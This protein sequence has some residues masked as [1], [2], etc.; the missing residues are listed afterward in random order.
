VPSFNSSVTLSDNT[1]TLNP[2]SSGNFVSGSKSVNVT[3]TK[4]WNDNQVTAND[5]SSGKSGQSNN[6]NI[7]PGSVQN[8]IVRSNPG[9]LGNEIGNLS[10]NLNNQVT[11]YAAGYDQW[12]NYVRDVVADWGKTGTLDSPSPLSGTSTTFLPTTAQTSGQVYADSSGM[13][14]Y[15]GT[16]TVGSIHYVLIRDADNGGGNVVNTSFITADDTL[17]LYAAAYDEGDNYLGAAIVD[18]SSSGSLQPAISS[19]GMSMITFAPTTAPASGQIVADHQTALDYTTGT[20]TV[21]QGAPV[22]NIVLHPNPKSIPAHPDSFSIITSDVIYD[23]DGN[24]IAEGELFTVSTT[25]GSI[26]APADQ[27]A[28][29]VGHQVSSNWSSQINFTISGESIGGSAIIHANSVGKGNAFGDTTL[30]ISNID[31]VSTNSVHSKVSQGQNNVLVGMTVKNRGT[32]NLIIPPDGASLRFRDSFNI[33]R[34]GDYTVTR[35]DTFS[36]IQS[37]GGQKILNFNVN[38]SPSATSDSISIDGNFNGMVNGKVVNDTTASQVH[39]WLVQTPPGLRIDRITVSADTVTQGKTTTVTMTVQNDGD[40]SFVIDSDSLT[41]WAMTQARD[42]THEYGQFPIPSNPDTIAGHSSQVL[43]YTVQ[44]GAAATLD[45]IVINGKVSGRDVNS[46]FSYTDYNADF[47]DGW[48]VNLASDVLI[49]EFLPDQMTVTSG[50]DRDWYIK[51]AVTNSGGSDLKLDSTRVIFTIGAF[52]ISSQYLVVTPNSFMSGGSDTLGAGQS[53]TLQFKI[54]KTGTTLGTITIE[55]II[56]LNDMVSGQIIKN[57]FTGVIV[58]SPAQLKIDYVRTS[59]P[60]VTVSQTFPWKTI[61]ALTNSGGS[62]VLV[63]TTQIQTFISFLGDAD[64]VV[65]TPGGFYNSGNFTLNAGASDSLFFTVDTT[66]KLAGDRQINAKVIA[67]EINSDRIINIPKNTS[68]EVEQPANIRIAKTIAVAPNAPYVDSDQPFQIAVV[69]ENLGQDAARD[70]AIALTTDSLSTILNP[71]DTLNT[72]SGGESD[73][74]K[75]NLRAHNGWIIDEV[76]TANIDTAFAENTPELDKIFVSPA[77]DSVDTVTVQRPAKMKILSVIPSQDTVRALIYDE[78][79]VRIAVQDS[80]A[81][82]I[83][84][85]QPSENDISILMEGEAQQDY[86]IIP[87]TGLKNSQDLVLSWWESDTLVYRV[88]RTG[89]RSGFGRIRVNLSGTYLNTGIPFDVADSSGI[90]IQPSADVFID[91][92]EPVCPNINQYGIGQVNTS[93]QFT[94]K[95]KIRNT[96]GERV[97]DT[98]VSLTASGYSAASDTIPFIAQS[99]FAWA[100]FDVAAQPT[101]AEQVNFIT[102]IESAISHEGGLP[103]T[104]GPASDS[105]AFMRVHEPALLELKINKADSIFSIGKLGV[106]RVTVENLGTADVDSSGELSVS[107]PDGYYVVVNEQQKSAD[108][109]SFKIDE[110]IAWQVNP[111]QYTSFNDTIVVEIRRPP[112][113][114]NTDSFA[115]IVNTDPFDTLV[116]KTVPSML[117][118]NSFRITAPAGAMDDTL[119][120]FQDFWV[121]VDVS[122]SENID[123]LCASL[124]L[125]EGYGFGIGFDS[126][127][128]IVNNR[129]T[130]KLKASETDHPVPE[131]IKVKVFGTTGYDIQTDL[132][133]IAVITKKRASLSIRNVHITWPK[134]DTTLSTGQ[135]FDLQVFVVN[136]GKANI[137]GSA[138]LKLNFGATGVTAVQQDTIKP[139]VP[140][141]PITWRLKAPDVVTASAPIIV[142]LDTIPDD[143]NTNLPVNSEND[144]EYF[145]VSTQNSGA[146]VIDSLWITSPS[147]AIDKVLSTHQNFTVEANVRWYNTTSSPSISLQLEQGFTTVESNP[148]TPTGTEQQGRVSWTIKAPEDPKQ[149][150]YSW[151][152]LTAEDAGSLQE[153][154]IISDSLKVDVV[155]RSEVQLNA[156]IISPKSAVD[157]VV[158]TGQKFVVAAFVSNSGDANLAG[159]YSATIV[160]PEGYALLGY[161]TQTTTFNDTLYWE[162]ESPNFEKEAKNITVQLVS[163]PKDANTSVPVVA[164]AILQGGIVSI[165][166][167]TEEKSVMIS[168]FYPR[169]KYTIT[170]GDTSVAMLGLELTCSGDANSNN[171]LFS[172]VKVKLKDRLGNLILNPGNV[173]SR[174]A[175]VKYM[176]NS[177]VYG[178]VTNIPASQP[179]EIL[180]SKIDTLKPEIPNRVVFRVDV[181]ANT[182]I[183]DFK[184]AIDS[185]NALYLVD[186]ESPQVPRLKDENGQN[187]KVLDF[188][189][190]STVIIESDFD[191]AFRNF[192]NPFGVL[193]RP[194]TKFIYYLDQDTDID[195]RIYTLIGELVWSRS[196][197][198]TD[199]QGKEGSHEGDIF[200]D[201]RN[202]RGYKVLNGVYIARISTG[203]GKSALTKIAVI[204]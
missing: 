160:P 163:N 54:D 70:V 106:V 204:K 76:F 86:T 95:A 40:A 88:T 112:R 137:E 164:E 61:V 196:Y 169:D 13:R 18:W 83:E 153:F 152:K 111:S 100:S 132:D 200:W 113:D 2:T 81:G 187:L 149:D 199:P 94:V 114:K 105:V 37:N 43:T 161:Q 184:L 140:G 123:S 4:K 159:N 147:G 119:S 103:A 201:G 46:N 75:F 145:W 58:Q 66:G 49:P 181:L 178:Q 15:T 78:W 146:A 21:K 51:M 116:V 174:V 195:I 79:Q 182:E 82:F 172:G 99:G 197:S 135:L 192:P 168:T 55:G 20:I 90:Y 63:D 91:I 60:E 117:S 69:V 19:A 191:E 41:F 35:T 176:E 30:A 136:N 34:S 104:I 87:P 189:S 59:Q 107:M 28:E 138:Y 131:L 101:P 139:F 42:V 162:I 31:I 130:W 11:F 142:S 7:N 10:L 72:V 109:I 98:I 144:I 150:T 12:N 80:G 52:D 141:I 115:S 68:I 202:D 27:A 128:T 38:V 44:V 64:Y 25:L 129:A 33:N 157:R 170:R 110:Q 26:T 3:I 56:Y 190:N 127:K 93:Q 151:L 193:S 14:D 186:E 166:I 179:I 155:N 194:L 73:T 5:P 177:L 8:I 9:G 122:A 16:I 185:T 158:S 126:V 1:G 32:E 134:P 39:K 92:T 97:D 6:F 171:I 62:D 156:N 183:S 48:R 47:V 29:I 133:S 67:N 175:V 17:R 36:V 89:I 45:T 121:Q 22:G 108:T 50:Q 180:F 57:A 125:P 65:T 148:K 71:I 167:Q 24:L 154:S 96:G 84:L 53:D 74:L 23:S 198:S 124:V 203:N 118:I 85:N 102:K 77:I 173:I 143:E 165:P 188:T 120:T